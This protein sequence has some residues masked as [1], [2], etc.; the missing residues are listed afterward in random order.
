[1]SD[2][3]AYASNGPIEPF[4]QRDRINRFFLL[5][6]D[7]AVLARIAGL[8]VGFVASFAL[9]LFG[10]FG[11]FLLVLALMAILVTGVRYGF[12]IIERSSKGFLL[13]SDYPLTDDDLVSEYLPYKYAAMTLVFGVLATFLELMSG[14]N[15]FVA[16]VAWLFF[17]VAIIPAA[18][19]RLVITGSLRGAL[20][21]TEMIE[22]IRRIGKPY[23]ALAAFI[24]VAELCRSYGLA[25]LA[26]GGGLSVAGLKTGF[27][28]GTVI[29][30]LLLSTAFWYFTYMICGLVGYAMYQFADALDISVMGPGE[31]AMRSVAN[32]RTINVKARTRDALIGQMVSAGDIKEAIDLL[33]HDLGERPNDLSLHARLHRLLL[34][35]N[36]TPRIEH[37][38]DS[39]LKLLVKSENWREAIELV[40]E[41]KARRAD[42]MPREVDHIAPL[43][44]AALRQ[45]KPQLAGQLITGFDKKHAVH[46]DVPKIYL[47]GAQLMAEWGGKPEEAQRI[48]QHLLKRYPSDAVATEAGRYL[49][50]LSRAAQPQ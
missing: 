21:P 33:S 17:F 20:N 26:A 48:L 14:G 6:L 22:M 15:E 24:F 42:W 13:P 46:S 28:V 31:Q 37:H 5:P 47:I 9:L 1:M 40:E 2:A 10:G 38:T 50:V 25:A 49:Q 34:A 7:K 3:Y 45:S 35:E 43:A 29:Q 4:W 19:M 30:L 36:S 8:S 18:T 12:K 32:A 16:I 23:A 44:Q 11:V 27:G 39:Y 41:A